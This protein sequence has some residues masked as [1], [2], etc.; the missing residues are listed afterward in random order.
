MILIPLPTSAGNHQFYNAL[1]FAKQNAA[2]MIQENELNDNIVENQILDLFN[3]KKKLEIL[4]E[5]ANNFIIKDA[6]NKIV[7]HIKE[8]EGFRC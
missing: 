8:L 3:S 1:S 7:N 4:A 5:N 2:I 6:T